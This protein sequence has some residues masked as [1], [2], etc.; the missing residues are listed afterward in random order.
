MQPVVIFGCGGQGREMASLLAETAASSGAP[1]EVLG[2]VDDAPSPDNAQLVTKLGF[3]LLGGADHISVFPPQTAYVIGIAD[4]ATRERLAALADQAGWTPLTFIHSTS[5][6]GETCTLGPGTF[7]WPGARLTTNISVGQHV[8]INQNVTI[9]HDSV[10]ADFVTINPSAAVSGSVAI[11][12][13]ALVGAGAVVLQGR[14]VGQDAIV[15]ASA[16]VTRDV[17]DSDIVVGIPARS[18]E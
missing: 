8:H 18:Q 7:V 14:R 6:V 4:G 9:G 3:R 1:V 12:E 11:G 10:L 13:R 15:G 17:A 5:S 16:C 2:F